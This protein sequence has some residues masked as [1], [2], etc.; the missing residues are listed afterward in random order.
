MRF[1][2]SSRIG[3]PPSWTNHVA[4]KAK[5][6]NEILIHANMIDALLSFHHPDSW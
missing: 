3:Y 2:G 5:T 6:A 4:A 1:K